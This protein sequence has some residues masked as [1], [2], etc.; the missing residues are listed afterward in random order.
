MLRLLSLLQTHRYWPGGELADRLEVSARTLRRDVERLREL[1]YEVDAVRGVAGGYQLRAGGS[2][3]PL[4]L[5]DEEAVAVAV[6][7]RGAAGV[8][9]AVAGGPDWALQALTK[10]VGLM[11]PHL[12]RR[13]DAVRSQTDTPEPWSGT[14]VIDA[15]VLGTIAQ[16]CR[17]DE[18]LRFGYA[19]RDAEPSHRWV[20][21]HRL[22]ALGRRWY[23]VAYDRDRQD[24]RTFRVDRISAPEPTGQRFRPRELPA[25]DAVEFV[26]SG[27]R[28]TQVHHEVRVRIDATPEQ[29]TAVVGR[30]GRVSAVGD[31]ALLE[32]DADSLGWPLMVLGEVGADFTVE[33]PPA[34]AEAVA[35][36]AARFGRAA[37]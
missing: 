37:G 36:V 31:G 26:R 29:V 3:A 21:P 6:A 13:M 22:V 18:P 7:L 30:W 16:A 10:V 9:A 5:T 1:G 24:W 14:P 23:L 33:S 28:S 19:A 4:L 25:G 35:E 15:G 32:M 20:E 27:I 17:D 12:R 34:L 11:P 2:M 8:A